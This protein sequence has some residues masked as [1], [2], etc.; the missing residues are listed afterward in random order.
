MGRLCFYP[1]LTLCPHSGAARTGAWQPLGLRV[2]RSLFQQLAIKFRWP[3]TCITLQVMTVHAIQFLV[4]HGIAVLFVCVLAEQSG[5]PV[6]SVPLLLTVGSLASVGRINPIVSLGVA[7]VACL[8]AD[9]LWYE[10]GRRGRTNLLLESAKLSQRPNSWM[11][12]TIAT[13]GRHGA[14]ALLWA[15]FLPGPNMASPLAGISGLTRSRFLFL[16]SL[17]SFIW[18]GGY[19]GFGYLFGKQ[20]ERVTASVSRLGSALL[21][22]GLAVMVAVTLARIIGCPRPNLNRRA[23]WYQ[24]WLSPTQLIPQVNSARLHHP[25]Q[26]PVQPEDL[27]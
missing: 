5:L 22:F 19:I 13:F 12:R 1:D 24:S 25:L 14:G 7:L 8:T 11:N 17:A 20:L 27:R 18:A 23:Y 3:D 26:K 9:G 4:D 2:E 16:D 6:P 10:V 15:K 21:V